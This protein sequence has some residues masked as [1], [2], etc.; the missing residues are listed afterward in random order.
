MI[1]PVIVVVS[2]QRLFIRGLVDSEK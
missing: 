2:M 1:P